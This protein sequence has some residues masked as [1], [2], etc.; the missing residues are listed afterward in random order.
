MGRLSWGGLSLYFVALVP[1]DRRKRGLAKRWVGVYCKQMAYYGYGYSFIAVNEQCVLFHLASL[2][3][4]CR[5][6]QFCDAFC[7]YQKPLLLF[8]ARYGVR[9][10]H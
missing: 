6:M 9:A 8:T 4:V 1:G 7:R 10:T 3:I 5:V 2:I